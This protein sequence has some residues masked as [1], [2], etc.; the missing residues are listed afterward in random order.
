M[1]LLLALSLSAV[2]VTTAVHAA[3]DRKSLPAQKMTEM[4]DGEVRKIDREARKITLRHPEIKQLD[5][6]AMTMVFRVKDEALLDKVKTGDKVRFRAEG[7]KGA[8][9]I[10]ELEVSK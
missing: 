7:N 6:P 9:T 10:T 4:S 3:E 5:M 8:L 2:L 1:K